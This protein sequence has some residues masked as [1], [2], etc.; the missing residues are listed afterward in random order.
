MTWQMN[1]L[2]FFLFISF[3]S[4]SRKVFLP[5]PILQWRKTKQNNTTKITFR[6]SLCQYCILFWWRHFLSFKRFL[7]WCNTFSRWFTVTFIGNHEISVDHVEYLLK[8]NESYETTLVYWQLIS[9]KELLMIKQQVHINLVIFLF[10][11]EYIEKNERVPIILTRTVCNN[12]RGIWQLRDDYMI[13]LTW[14]LL[15]NLCIN[16]TDTFRS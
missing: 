6:I 9:D 10:I 5:F 2:F 8:K 1:P 7:R 11:S 13:N 12:C 16:F 4:P 15:G 14:F 3:Y